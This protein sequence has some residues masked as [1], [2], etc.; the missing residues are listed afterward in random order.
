MAK[1]IA[2]IDCHQ[3]SRDMVTNPF[4]IEMRRISKE[5]KGLYAEFALTP[6]GRVQFGVDAVREED[7]ILLM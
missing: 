1:D 4:V 6:W 7:N 5:M 3:K 2:T